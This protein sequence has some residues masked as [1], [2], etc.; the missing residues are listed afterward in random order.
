MLLKNASLS[1]V[2]I[3]LGCELGKRFS[4]QM[5]QTGFKILISE[6]IDF[7]PNTVRRD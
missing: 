6:I 3:I 1:K 2:D 4:T 5:E 7:K